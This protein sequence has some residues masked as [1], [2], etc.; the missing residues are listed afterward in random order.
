M[1][2]NRSFDHMLGWLR[3]PQYRIDGL[4][5]TQSNADRAGEPV[6]ATKDADYSGDYDPDAAH[7]F[8][9]VTEQIFGTQNPLAGAAPSMSGFVKNYGAVSESVSKSHHVMKCF[10]VERKQN[11]LRIAGGQ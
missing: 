11:Y 10:E 9:D 3:S 7:D 5:G 6:P 4:D 2:E 8:L 1:L